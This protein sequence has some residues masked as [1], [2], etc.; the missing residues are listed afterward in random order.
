MKYILIVACML[1]AACS[2]SI[3]PELM[4]KAQQLCQADGG[5]STVSGNVH[6]GWYAAR[7]RVDLHMDCSNGTHIEAV[8]FV[9]K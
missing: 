6:S 2:N 4:A 5:V 8:W 1:L 9:A 3:T 7:T